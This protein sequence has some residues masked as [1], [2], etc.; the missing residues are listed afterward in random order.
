MMKEVSCNVIR[1]LLPLYEDNVVSED[2]AE[3]VQDHLRTCPNCRQELKKLRL[4]V[5]VPPDADAE[6]LKGF[7][8]RWR[9]AHVRAVLA[10]LC[11]VAVLAAIVGGALWYTRPQGLDALVSEVTS[12]RYGSIRFSSA[13]L[14]EQ[15]M[16]SSR[17]TWILEAADPGDE[18]FDAVLSL[19]KT[20]S[21]RASLRNLLGGR[22]D[23]TNSGGGDSIRLTLK[24]GEDQYVTLTL[25]SSDGTLWLLPD[26]S[27]GILTYTQVNGQLFDAL[28]GIFLKYGV[29]TE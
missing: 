2:T 12:L 11:V 28:T 15:H 7:R 4:P 3:L 14:Y 18:V 20:G 16:N 5:S 8:K 29:P 17:D 26:D 10:V 27:G 1:D 25:F 21:Y 22:S 6:L 24:T 19:L 23:I 9:R 13:T